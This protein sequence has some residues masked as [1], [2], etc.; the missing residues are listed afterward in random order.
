MEVNADKLVINPCFT[1]E[2]GLDMVEK[3][4][5]T[6]EFD[7]VVV[8]SV[9]SLVPF[10]S[11]EIDLFFKSGVDVAGDILETAVLKEVITK[12][13]NSYTYLENKFATSRDAAIKFLEEHP[14]KMEEIKGKLIK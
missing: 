11:A 7:L 2:E 12:T 6:G 10:L 14:E 3:L 1:G 8:D 9:A 5:P 4:V 13:G